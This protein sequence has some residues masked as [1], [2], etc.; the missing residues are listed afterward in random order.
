MKI[1]WGWGILSWLGVWMLIGKIPQNTSHKNSTTLK[2][3]TCSTAQ[4][5]TF[6]ILF[7]SNQTFF[8]IVTSAYF[9]SLFNPRITHFLRNF[10]FC[11][12][13]PL[14]IQNCSFQPQKQEEHAPTPYDKLCILGLGGAGLSLA[15]TEIERVR[16]Q[17]SDTEWSGVCWATLPSFIRK[18][19][20]T[21]AKLYLKSGAVRVGGALTPF[22]EPTLRLSS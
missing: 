14:K 5:T 6:I 15:K 2:K 19:R 7:R 11:Q 4:N 3:Q 16:S 17:C 1:T 10:S 20:G 8:S 13:D 22:Q 21:K 18:K 12:S 9:R